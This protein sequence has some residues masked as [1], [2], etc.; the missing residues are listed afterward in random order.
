L[1]KANLY[2]LLAILLLF[3][4]KAKADDQ[5]IL[6]GTEEPITESLENIDTVKTVVLFTAGDFWQELDGLPEMRD[7]MF[8]IWD[9]TLA[10]SIPHFYETSTYGKVKLTG[11][12]YPGADTA[13]LTDLSW[14]AFRNHTA[15]YA[16]MMDIYP[17]A[18]SVIDFGLYDNRGQ[19]GS[20]IPDGYVDY[21]V[22]VTLTAG[23]RGGWAKKCSSYTTNDTNSLGD[24]VRIKPEN[25]TWIQTF[26]D[27]YVLDWSGAPGDTC[28]LWSGYPRFVALFIHETEHHFEYYNSCIHPFTSLGFDYQWGFNMYDNSVSSP[29][30]P[31]LQ[32]KRGWSNPYQ[33]VTP[34]YSF[35]VNDRNSTDSNSIKLIT[36]A[37]GSQGFYI[38]GHKRLVKEEENWPVPNELGTLIWHYNDDGCNLRNEK[39]WDIEVASGLYDWDFEDCSA[40]GDTAI[41]WACRANAGDTNCT[42]YFDIIINQANTSSG[43]DSLDFGEVW[44]TNW[45]F[46]SDSAGS[47]SAFW[48][49][50]TY[51]NFDG[52]TNPSSDFHSNSSPYPQNI[53]SHIGVRNI[54]IDTSNYKIYADLL[55]NNWYDTLAANHTTWGNPSQSTGYSITG[56]VVVKAG[57]T[58][59]I[60][61]GTTVYFQ[62]DEDMLGRGSD[63]SLS[64]LIIYGTLIAE[65][66]SSDSILFISSNEQLDTGA[67]GDWVGIRFMPGSEGSMR[68]CAIRNAITAMEMED[69]SSVDLSYCMIEDNDIKGIDNY[70]GFLSIDSSTISSSGTYGIYSYGAISTVD[71]CD[72]IKHIYGIYFWLEHP[73]SDS[74]IIT[75]CDIYNTGFMGGAPQYG[76]YLAYTDRARVYKCSVRNFDQGGIMFNNSDGLILNN[77]LT[78]AGEYGIYAYNWS[79]PYIRQCLIDSV[80]ISVKTASR[81]KPDLG[82]TSDYGNCTLAGDDYYIYHD[83]YVW[84]PDTMFAIYNY[85]GRMTPLPGK[86]YWSSPAGPIKYTP[87]RTSAPPAPRLDQGL[88]TP[89][90]FTLHQNYPNPFN[91]NTVISFSLDG[92][93]QTTVAIYNILGQKIATPI[94]EFMDAGNHS[95]IWDGRNNS[96][97]Q[98]ASGIYFYTIQSGDRLDS[99]KML[100][101]R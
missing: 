70:K 87:F 69:T 27:D 26:N 52:T 42:K 22:F 38:T 68:Y 88:E 80:D 44:E 41:E 30:N 14:G 5:L 100:L 91:A 51:T 4:L 23:E 101:L 7:W 73:G 13:F 33:P 63:T 19:N 64:E 60:E 36:S 83:Y 78:N 1:K 66:T 59:T 89:F 3:L 11:D 93:E 8:D 48:D 20:S 96:G 65:G 86:F 77:T 61:Q 74:T 16:Y 90:E 25:S 57:D 53:R 99:K 56:D 32:Y 47:G 40:F 9:T 55:V 28:Y 29:Y 15:H 6:C 37:S 97:S 35:E 72:I 54:N 79:F 18:D 95:F 31:F 71:N 84:V 17:K 75:Y 67:P 81:S 58:L 76:I 49:G 85:Y 12:S 62:A 98:V 46:P 34:I 39:M 24:T 50:V 43:Y 94:N 82:T 10:N 45:P 21:L 92:S 2:T